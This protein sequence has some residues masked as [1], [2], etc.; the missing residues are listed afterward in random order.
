VRTGHYNEC[1]PN[2]D[3]GIF[4]CVP[5]RSSRSESCWYVPSGE[6][7]TPFDPLIFFC[8]FVLQVTN[9]ASGLPQGSPPRVTPKLWLL[10]DFPFVGCTFVHIAHTLQRK[11]C[12]WLRDRC[13]YFI[14]LR[15]NACTRLNTSHSYEHVTP[16]TN[17]VHSRYDNPAWKVDFSSECSMSECKCETVDHIAVG[18]E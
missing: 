18:R 6:R 16:L 1:N 4:K 3:T 14:R 8:I 2:A 9:L 7:A 13:D 10:S 15:A 12:Y 17:T 5:Q 11:R